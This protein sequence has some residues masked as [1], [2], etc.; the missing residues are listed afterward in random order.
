M[1]SRKR[2]VLP[3]AVLILLLSIGACSSKP[4]LV[5]QY[6]MPAKT[7]T[8]AGREVLPT[9]SDFRENKAFLSENAQKSL[10]GFNDTYSLVAIKEDGSGN[11]LGVYKIDSLLTELFK[12]RL[13]NMGIRVTPYTNSPEY[14]LEVDL[15]DF[16]L[17]LVGSK[18]V[19]QMSYQASLL[20]DSRQLAMESVSG[21]AERL[22]VMGKGDAE[23]LLG[24]LMSDMVNKLDLAKLFLKARI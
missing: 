21:S 23:K 9:V 12:L 14:K 18:W 2:S 5:V 3:M 8:L 10:K 15:G 4:F 6:Q 17:D 20:K 11:L 16:K 22:K 19:M 1:I 7:D 24:E 13:K